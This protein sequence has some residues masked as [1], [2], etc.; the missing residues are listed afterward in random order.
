MW[1]LSFRVVRATCGSLT[2][3]AFMWVNRVR[4]VQVW[5]VVRE[6]STGWVVNNVLVQLLF[7]KMVVP[8]WHK[9]IILLLF[10]TVCLLWTRCW[11]CCPQRSDAS[12][13]DV[14]RQQSLDMR[15]WPSCVVP[16]IDGDVVLSLQCTNQQQSS[17]IEH[18]NIT[19]F[20]PGCFVLRMDKFMCW[21]F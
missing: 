14:S 9:W 16:F 12:P 1:V 21:L 20:M 11:H 7:S 6:L 10:Q 17:C 15:S 3:P 2:R 4:W 8:I 18:H 19:L 13:S 5:M